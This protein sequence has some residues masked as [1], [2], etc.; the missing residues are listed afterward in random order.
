[1]KSFVRILNT[2]IPYNTLGLLISKIFNAAGKRSNHHLKTIYNASRNHICQRE[3]II[4]LLNKLESLTQSPMN[5]LYF[6]DCNY[7]VCQLALL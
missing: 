6:T 1:M 7:L 4:D 5:P 2:K 3:F